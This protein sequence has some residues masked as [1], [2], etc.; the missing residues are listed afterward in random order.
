MQIG[1]SNYMLTFSQL[2]GWD[3]QSFHG[4]NMGSNLVRDSLAYNYYDFFESQMKR[5]FSSLLT[6]LF[7]VVVSISI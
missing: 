2:P 7:Y 3:R 6:P 5:A 1:F 4:E